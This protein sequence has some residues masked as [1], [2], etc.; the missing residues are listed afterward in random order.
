LEVRS[1]PSQTDFP[2]L[3]LAQQSAASVNPFTFD[4]MLN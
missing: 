3:P 2:S 4:L 1:R